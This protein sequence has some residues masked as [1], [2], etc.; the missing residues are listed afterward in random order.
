MVFWLC[1]IIAFPFVFLLFPTRIYGRKY[2]KSVKKKPTIICA[3]HQTNNDAV[4]MKARVCP[5]SKIM[6][7]ESLF[8][9]KFFG[10]LL[11]QF[12]AY[13]VD[14][15]GNDIQA[16]KITLRIL[17]DGK[18]ILLFPEGTRVK[19]AESVEVKN[20]LVLFALK[21]DAY[22]VP[23]IFRKVTLPFVFN[24]LLIGKPFRLSDYEEFKE[25]KT[26]KETLNRASKIVEEKIEYLKTV[27]IKDYKKQYKQFKEEWKNK[28]VA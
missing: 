4:I 28:D 10:W 9:S 19:N 8:K 27:N 24:K 3:N 2:L 16:I 22:I 17:K 15:G 26:D 6:A 5:K 12:G 18:Q 13:P 1:L 7:K 11:K 14:R 21:T 25:A 20:G 23:S